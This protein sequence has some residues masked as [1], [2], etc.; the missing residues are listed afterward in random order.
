MTATTQNIDDLNAVI[1]I[2]ISKAE[3]EPKVQRTLNGYVKTASIPGFR[4]GEV[5]MAYIEKQYGNPLRLDAIN[6]MLQEG[7]TKHIESEKLDILGQ[8]IPKEGINIDWEANEN[9]FEFEVGKVPTFN[10]DISSIPS[11][12]RY[13]IKA[14]ENM[15]NEQLDRGRKQFGKMSPKQEIVEKEDIT[16]TFHNPKM[17]IDTNAQFTLSQFASDKAK[18][19]FIGKKVGD[20]VSI[21]TNGLFD[22]DHKLMDF[23]KI[24]HDQVHNLD[25]MLEFTIEE[26]NHTELAEI[27]PEFL[28]K[29]FGAGKVADEAEARSRIK[30]D[31]EQQLTSQSDQKFLNDSTQALLESTKFDL[32][33]EF[34]IKWIQVSGKVKMAAEQAAAEYDKSENALRY[35]L[36]EAKVI[37]ENG[38]KITFEELKEY[39]ANLI[40]SQMAQFGQMDPSKEEI[41]AIVARVIGN[42]EEVKRLSDQLMSAKMLNLFKEKVPSTTKT[43][44]YP[45]FVNEM[46]G[47]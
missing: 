6:K 31:I 7:L 29:I 25:T 14:D 36:I 39:T 24:E 23:L 3:Y 9:F 42:Q 22:D 26:I 33:K 8:P 35:Q 41:D 32:P 20:V 45:N 46:Y 4:K 11:V 43:M 16:G 5:P 13:E 1:T 12:V 27:T 40:K 44:D 37:E 15:V 17:G 10:V 34:L 38:L 21:E 18:R 30:A 28:E 2:K 19:A 47:E